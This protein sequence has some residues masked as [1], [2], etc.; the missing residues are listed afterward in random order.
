MK[1]LALPLG[2]EPAPLPPGRGYPVHR[3]CGGALLLREQ[4]LL[5]KHARD[6]H[7]GTEVLVCSRCLLGVD[8]PREIVLRARDA[9][10][11]DRGVAAWPRVWN[12]GPVEPLRPPALRLEFALETRSEANGRDRFARKRR[13]E[14]AIA[15]VLEEVAVAL[16]AG[17]RVPLLGPWCVRM[18]R[19]SPHKALDVG[20]LWSA[21]KAVEDA[22]AHLLAIDDGS[23]LFAACVAQEP[24]E[25]L[26]VRI[27]VWSAE[28]L[29][30]RAS[31][32]GPVLKGAGS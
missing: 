23:P 25:V 22:V 6:E 29:E 12:A 11:V 7:L 27:E 15:V 10:I 17:Q 13:T 28:A 19:L 18:T 26:G 3:G 32:A 21:L 1:P 8:A 20:N 9:A 2:P 30:D 5:S 31:P 14:E 24:A 16:A 4:L